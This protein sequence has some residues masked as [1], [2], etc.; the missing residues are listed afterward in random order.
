MKRVTARPVP[1]GGIGPGNGH[2][3]TAVQRRQ[4]LRGVVLEVA[5]LAL[6][7]RIGARAETRVVQLHVA[8]APGEFDRVEVGTFV[9]PVPD[10]EHVLVTAGTGVPTSGLNRGQVPQTC[11]G[12]RR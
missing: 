1:D 5:Q 9:D 11:L 7:K 2:G 8:A 12:E 10:V 3:L 6:G 4:Y